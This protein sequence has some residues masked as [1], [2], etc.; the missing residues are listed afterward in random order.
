MAVYN[1][2][3]VFSN[4]RDNLEALTRALT[5]RFQHVSIEVVGCAAIFSG[6]T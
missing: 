5:Q 1:K 2:K 3:G 4:E 6:R